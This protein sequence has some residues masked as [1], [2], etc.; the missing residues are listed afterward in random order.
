MITFISFYTSMHH[1]KTSSESHLN[2]R[3]L[4]ELQ[5]WFHSQKLFDT[6]YTDY[7]PGQIWIFAQ[8]DS[9]H[10]GAWHYISLFHPRQSSVFVEL[11]SANSFVV[12]ENPCSRRKLPYDLLE[13]RQKN[14]KACSKCSL[15]ERLCA[16]RPFS[17][18]LVSL[19][20]LRIGFNISTK[21]KQTRQ[22]MLILSTWPEIQVFNQLNQMVGCIAM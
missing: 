1:W 21:H 9:I 10:W 11:L 7:F 16:K 8:V 2:G 20:V 15:I 18:A 22:L 13:N 5:L 14:V 19:F 3:L 12:S 6:F 4:C 17:H